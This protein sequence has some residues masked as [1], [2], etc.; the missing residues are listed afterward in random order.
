MTHPSEDLI[1]RFYS[2]RAEGDRREVRSLLAPGVKWHDPYPPPHGGDLVGV[3]AVLGDVFDAADAITGGTTQLWLHD[4]VAN[5][6]HAVALVHW[7]VEIRGRKMESKE[8]AV[9]HI[10]SGCIEEVWFYPEDR[11]AA[12]AFFGA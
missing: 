10:E 3:D 12:A 8:I 4:V 2:A 5:D 9:F 11:E 1:R 7:S 6:R